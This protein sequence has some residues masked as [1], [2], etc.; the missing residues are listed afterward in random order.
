MILAARAGESLR[1][2]TMSGAK[3]HDALAGRSRVVGGPASARAGAIDPAADAL[4]IFRAI[5]RKRSFAGESSLQES[6]H[7][8]IIAVRF[9]AVTDALPAQPLLCKIRDRDFMAIV[10]GFRA[11]LSARKETRLNQ[12]GVEARI[13]MDEHRRP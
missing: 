11:F 13:Y 4:S 6:R 5:P 7:A 10:D 3:L 12:G 2:E 9:A 1:G 8:I